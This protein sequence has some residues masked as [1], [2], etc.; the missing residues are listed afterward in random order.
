MAK[1]TFEDS[2]QKLDE[3]VDSLENEELSLEDSVKKFEE[4]M[5]LSRFCAEKLDEAEKKIT[6][7]KED[8]SGNIKE[9]PFE[10][11]IETGLIDED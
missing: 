1:K 8:L 4:G 7:L 2:L 11:N 9:E 10:K 3:I 5:K 6:I